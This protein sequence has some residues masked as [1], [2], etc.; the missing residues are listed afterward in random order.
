[1]FNDFYALQLNVHISDDVYTIMYL[2]VFV[3]WLSIF[4][5]LQCITIMFSG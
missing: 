3:Q 1:M 2:H 5:I 4:D